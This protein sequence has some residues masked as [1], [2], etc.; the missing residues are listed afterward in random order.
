[1]PIF[2]DPLVPTYG[3]NDSDWCLVRGRDIGIPSPLRITAIAGAG[4]G[5]TADTLITTNEPHGLSDGDSIKIVCNLT[6]LDEYNG[7]HTVLDADVSTTSFTIDK[8]YVATDAATYSNIRLIRPAISSISDSAVFLVDTAG[9]GDVSQTGYITAPTLAAYLDDEITVMPN[10]TGIGSVANALAMTFSD[11]TLFHDANNADTSFSIGTS[12]A[13]ALK[14]EVLNGGSNKTAEEIKISTATDSET[15]HHGKITLNVDGT[16]IATIDDDGIDLASGKAFTVNSATIAVTNHVTNDADDTMSGTLTIDKDVTSTDA[17]TYIGLDIDLDKTE[18]STSNN[19]LYGLR[20]DCD[21]ITATDGSNVMYGIYNTPTLTQAEDYGGASVTGLL[22]TVTGSSNG[23]SQ[24]YGIQQTITGS[25]TI[26]GILQTVTNGATDLQF[27][28]SADSGDY[29]SIATT[30]HGATTITTEDDDAT[31][32]DLTLDIDGDI[33]LKPAGGNVYVLDEGDR[34]IFDFN[35]I[36]PAMVIRDDADTGDYF[37]ISVLAHG[38]TTIATVDDDA[39]A[40]HLTLDVDGDIELNADGGTITFKDDTK[41]TAEI[42]TDGNLLIIGTLTVRGHAHSIGTAGSATATTYSA[43]TNTHDTVGKALTISGGSTTAGTTD[44]IAGG[45]LTLQGGQGKGTGVG[46]AIIFQTANAGS[47]GSS[48]NALAEKMRIHT[49][50]YVGIGVADPDTTLEVNGNIKVTH[51]GTTTSALKVEATALTSGQ[52]LYLDINDSLTTNKFNHYLSVIN[53]AK[54]GVTAHSQTSQTTGLAVFLAD[55][56][57][58]D[59]NGNVMMTG[60]LINVDSADAQGGISQTGL[61]INVAIDDVGDASNTYGIDMTV[62]DGGT[63]IIMKS[64]AD[65]YDYCSISTTA[66]GATTIA[67]VDSDDAEAAHLTFDIQGDT[68]FKGDIADGT[69][70]EVA[71]IDA[72]ASSLFIA[73]GKNI[74]FGNSG[75][76]I[77]G[78]GT[79]LDIVSS[80]DID[81]DAAGDVTLDADDGQVYLKDGGTEFARFTTASS[82]SGLFLFEAAG[83]SVDDYFAIYCDTAGKTTITTVDDAGADAHLKVAADGHVEFDNCAVGFDKLAGV[84]GTSGVIGDTANDST[85]IDFR[86]SNKY[87][88]EL[89]DGIGASETLNFIFPATSGNFLLVLIQDGSGSRLVHPDAWTAYASDASLCDNL[90]GAN[91]TDGEI[92]WAGGS[93]P[94]LTTTADKSDIVS[95]YWDADNQTAFAVASLN[96]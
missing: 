61:D 44:D 10:L 20:I 94:T 67:T 4:A 8:S 50:G 27:N 9:D 87:E 90:A 3:L 16:D 45:T 43:I 89:T 2:Y 86:L 79:D 68:I 93:A 96:F 60:A 30:T 31:A 1:M 36:N 84:F 26:I 6:A 59:V 23:T 47:S 63:D 32:A 85:D 37:R 72:S 38:A 21:N 40:A 76:Y 12:A 13:E 51:T 15:D 65:A 75:E 25:D 88:L 91:G 81:L 73:S 11:I 48:L 24:A 55:A 52:A 28:S 92:R 58:N 66:S 41:T 71:R 49:N 57:T 78:D 19:N 56:A 80:G 69:S 46:G 22:Q 83:S 14:I 33:V 39:T 29:F 54:S 34:N 42:D 7:L 64:S 35:P 74:E 70:T 17:G 95:I 5:G 62:M 53:Y 18:A 82:K 77:V